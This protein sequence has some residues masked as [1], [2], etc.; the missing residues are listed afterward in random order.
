MQT[1][2]V[3][4]VIANGERGLLGIAFSPKYNSTRELWGYYVGQPASGIT[5]QT[6]YIARYQATEDFSVADPS[7]VTIIWQLDHPFPNHNAGQ[8][9]FGL[10]GLLYV[11]LG[12]GTSY[13]NFHLIGGNSGDPFGNGQDLHTQWGKILRCDTCL[14][15]H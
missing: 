6:N 10:E 15:Y 1:I 3:D 11:S 7:T 14:H 4:Q 8:L 12:D 2:C 5:Y 9:K 13:C